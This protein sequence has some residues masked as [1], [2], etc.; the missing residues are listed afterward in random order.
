MSNDAQQQATQQGATTASGALADIS[1]FQDLM[2]R[3]RTYRRFDESKPI[4][5]E[6][7]LELV[8]VARLSPCG[9]NMQKLRFHVVSDAEERAL[10]FSHLGWARDLRDWDGPEPG[11]RP[12]GYILILAEGSG[13][14]TTSTDVGIAAAVMKLAAMQA[15]YGSCMVW[16]FRRELAADLDINQDLTVNLVL[17]LGAPGEKVVLEELPEDGSTRYWRDAEGVHHVPKRT[18]K[19]ILV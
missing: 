15:G 19:D 10:V 5:K 4:P 14:I 17:A 18:L 2:A 13:G 8:D 1:A 9:N 16:N 7:L 6:L 11:E 3:S 12:T